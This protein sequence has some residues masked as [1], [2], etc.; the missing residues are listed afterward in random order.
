MDM[1]PW[2][3][4]DL[5]RLK[6][7]VLCANCEV[8]SEGVNGHCAACGSEALLRLNQ[9]LGGTAESELNFDI[10]SSVKEITPEQYLTF[11]A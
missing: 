6:K 10:T 5:V 1:Q 9:L 7:A 4:A 2:L 11:A 8:I 3:H